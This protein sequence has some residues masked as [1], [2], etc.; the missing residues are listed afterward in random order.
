MVKPLVDGQRVY[1]SGDPT[2][3]GDVRVVCARWWVEWDTGESDLVDP[4]TRKLD[5]DV[6]HG[7][8]VRPVRRNQQLRRAARRR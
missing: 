1:Y 3:L 4:K 2:D 6:H 8:K 7:A 5:H